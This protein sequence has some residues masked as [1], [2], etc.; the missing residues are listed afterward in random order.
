MSANDDTRG[1]LITFEGSEGAGKSTQVERIAKR[2]EAHNQAVVVTREPGGTPIGE[3][4]RRLLMHSACGSAMTPETEL[5]LFAASRAQLVREV[6]RP[7]VDEGK[8]VLCDRFLDS[9]TV[10]QGVGR[11]IASEPVA[12]INKFAV[13]DLMPDITVII[14]L[15]AEIG[16]E[17]TR[18]RA[19]EMPDRMEQENIEF[20]RKVREGYLMLAKALPGRFIIADGSKSI[21]EVEVQIWEELRKRVI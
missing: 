19:R 14:D 11:R 12:M 5:L 4:I 17:R 9:T 21:D 1:Y 15:P 20:Y 2:F 10:Y 3:E 16:L 6:I 18:H 13:G 8:I 7:A